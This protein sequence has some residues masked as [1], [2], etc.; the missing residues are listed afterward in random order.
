LLKALVQHQANDS[1][2]LVMTL[3]NMPLS[4]ARNLPPGPR[5]VLVGLLLANGLKDESKALLST[6][7]NTPLLKAET[8]W[9]KRTLGG[10]DYPPVGQ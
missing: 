10:E 9:L 4:S 6:M 8:D 1:L 3:K 2:A 7:P 5:G